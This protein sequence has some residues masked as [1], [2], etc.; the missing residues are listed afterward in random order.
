MY[1]PYK[2]LTTIQLFFVQQC[3]FRFSWPFTFYTEETANIHSPSNPFLL[4]HDYIDLTIFA[5]FSIPNNFSL[6][7]CSPYGSY[8]ICLIILLAFHEIFF[9][10]ANNIFE[11]RRPKL[12]TLIQEIGTPQV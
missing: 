11:M 4:S 9:H 5:V 12:Y 7:N 10:F 8:S 1:L 3:D 6:H 2:L